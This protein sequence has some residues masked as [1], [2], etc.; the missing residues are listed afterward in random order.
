MNHFFEMNIEINFLCQ[1]HQKIL[2]KTHLK[3]YSTSQEDTFELLRNESPRVITATPCSR[4]LRGVDFHIWISPQ[5]DAK[6]KNIYTMVCSPQ[7]VFFGIKKISKNRVGWTVPLQGPPLFHLHSEFK[8]FFSPVR[9]NLF[10][11]FIQGSHLQLLRSWSK[12]WPPFPLLHSG[13][14]SLLSPFRGH[15]LIFFI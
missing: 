3:V 10:T 12:W 15:L 8:W 2:A 1:V 14:S 6:I 9:G 7:N 4:L 13:A 11:F 5:Y